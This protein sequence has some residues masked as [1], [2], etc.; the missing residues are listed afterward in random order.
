[1]S[2]SSRFLILQSFFIASK[3]SFKN[4]LKSANS[5]KPSLFSSISLKIFPI[6]V[7]SSSSIMSENL[8]NTIF[9]R[10]DYKQKSIKL[11]IFASGLYTGV[12]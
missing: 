7:V 4:F 5:S 11:S 6:S 3:F 1:M 2:S 10:L 8:L 9:L 12:S